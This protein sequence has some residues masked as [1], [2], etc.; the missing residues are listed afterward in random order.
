MAERPDAEAVLV[1]GAFG[2]GKTSAIEEI[3]D[4]LEA[5]GVRYGAIDLDWLSWFDPGSSGGH[6][7][8]MPVMLKNVDAVV[9]N[10]YD[11][12]V[13]RFALARMMESQRDVDDLRAALAMPLT[14]VR[15][16]LPF[17]EIAR[18]LHPR[19]RTRDR[20]RPR[21]VATVTR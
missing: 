15:L 16:T 14:V 1:T 9:G 19:G 6:R 4:I 10:Y 7:A 12:G 3:A 2:T 8:G 20:D 13:R 18:R 21:L 17:D 11:T 5:R